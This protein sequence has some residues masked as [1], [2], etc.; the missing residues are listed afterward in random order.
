MSTPDSFVPVLHVSDKF[1]YHYNTI[2]KLLYEN[3]YGEQVV[4][5]LVQLPP[6]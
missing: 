3:A 5:S 1:V 2:Y 4:V 6:R